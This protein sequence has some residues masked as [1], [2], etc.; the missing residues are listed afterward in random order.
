MRNLEAQEGCRVIQIAAT[1]EAR[2][3]QAR[4]QYP[5]VE[6]TKDADGHGTHS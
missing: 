2:P 4:K 6:V 3:T 5:D 1:S